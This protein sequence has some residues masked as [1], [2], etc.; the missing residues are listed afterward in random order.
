MHKSSKR[1]IHYTWG[2]DG[3]WNV[4]TADCEFGV[5]FKALGKKLIFFSWR[6]TFK[7]TLKMHIH[8]RFCSVIT[9]CKFLLPDPPSAPSVH[10]WCPTYPN[11]TLC[12]WAEPPS[13]PPAHYIATYRY[14]FDAPTSFNQTPFIQLVSQRWSLLSLI[15]LTA[16]DTSGKTTTRAFSSPPALH[17]PP[18]TSHHHLTPSRYRSV[19]FWVKDLRMWHLQQMFSFPVHKK[20]AF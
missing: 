1:E 13:S 11:V 3:C 17:S 12:S 2:L 19:Y 15:C 10:C 18:W 4:R 6:I 9:G 14:V 16:K 5:H 8:W 7:A 20:A